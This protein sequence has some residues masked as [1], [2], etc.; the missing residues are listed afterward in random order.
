MA[1]FAQRKGGHLLDN[2]Y[3]MTVCAMYSHVV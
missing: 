3:H 1:T 2:V